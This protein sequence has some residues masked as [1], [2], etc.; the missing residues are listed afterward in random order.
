MQLNTINDL[1][2][3]DSSKHLD[4]LGIFPGAGGG[5]GDRQDLENQVTVCSLS[6]LRVQDIIFGIL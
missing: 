5:G 1:N 3:M 4:P 2:A 6:S